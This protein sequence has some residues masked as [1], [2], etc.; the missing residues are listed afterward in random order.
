MLS[1]RQQTDICHCHDSK[2]F[3]VGFMYFFYFMCVNVFDHICSIDLLFAL[4]LCS[5][6]SVII[7]S[8]VSSGISEI[9]VTISLLLR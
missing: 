1:R 2:G 7:W 8:Q 5:V 9:L 4:D 3:D 6:I